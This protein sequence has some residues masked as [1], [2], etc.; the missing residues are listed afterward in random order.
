MYIYI[1]TLCS[2]F[3]HERNSIQAIVILFLQ[4]IL[5]LVTQKLF[6]NNHLFCLL[7]TG[8]IHV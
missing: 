1:F 3:Q 5:T 6:F 7:T 8:S 4:R 2:I